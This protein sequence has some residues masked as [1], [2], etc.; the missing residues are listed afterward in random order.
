MKPG[1]FV[2]LD[3][4][5][6]ALD[7]VSMTPDFG[8]AAYVSRVT[9]EVHMWSDAADFDPLPVDVEDD[10][11]YIA[12][13]DKRELDLG[14]QLVFSFVEEHL[15]ASA[16]A[17]RDIFR[18]RGAYGKF[19]DLLDRR[20]L[21][22]AWYDFEAAETEKALRAWGEENGLAIGDAPGKDAG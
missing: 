12:V 4:L 1:V 13:P 22:Q 11:L 19:K 16:D 7:V 14:Q 2:N 18:K 6:H 3:D 9:G 21:L 5:Q 15:G 20:G 8:N 17:V 10:S